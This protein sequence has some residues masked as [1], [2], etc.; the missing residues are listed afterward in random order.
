MDRVTG[1][2]DGQVQQVPLEQTVS[3]DHTFL[4]AHAIGETDPSVHWNEQID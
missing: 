1:A 3:D 4:E 2:G